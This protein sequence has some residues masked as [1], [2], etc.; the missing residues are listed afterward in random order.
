MHDLSKII[1]PESFHQSFPKVGVDGKS[2]EQYL[3]EVSAHAGIICSWIFFCQLEIL[4]C[5]SIE[6]YYLSAEEGRILKE[7]LCAHDSIYVCFCKTAI[8]ILHEVYTSVC[9]NW[10]SECFFY[11]LDYCPVA[12]THFVLVLLLCATVH[13]QQFASRGLDL[14]H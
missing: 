6:I 2:G 5:E 10:N 14:L 9:H 8:D 7:C 1:D 4:E 3:E 11:A 13:C 12:F